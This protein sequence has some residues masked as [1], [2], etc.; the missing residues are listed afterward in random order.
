MIATP[1]SAF[2]PT[3]Y[4][5]LGA[6]NHITPEPNNLINRSTYASS[7][8]IHI[9]DGTGLDIHT[10]GLSSFNLCLIL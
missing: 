1:F 8:Q 3:W 4:L 10:V 7:D 9:G 6:T 2:D 5:D